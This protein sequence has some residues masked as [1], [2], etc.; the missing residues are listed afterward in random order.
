MG[1]VVSL[2][3]TQCCVMVACWWVWLWVCLTFL[4]V[5]TDVLL[6]GGCAVVTLS[7]CGQAGVELHPQPWWTA[8]VDHRL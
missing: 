8:K 4:I 6:C 1:S 7:H 2:G 5:Q 3:S